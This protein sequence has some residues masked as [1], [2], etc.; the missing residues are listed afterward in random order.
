VKDEDNLIKIHVNQLSEHFDSV[1]IFCTKRTT[2][3]SN[4]TAAFAQGTGDWYARVG[5]VQEWIVDNDQRIR[6]NASKEEE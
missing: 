2:D 5:H 6:N 3:G 4:D 1:Q